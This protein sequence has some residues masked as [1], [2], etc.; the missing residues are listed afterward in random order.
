MD[1]N[2]LVSILINNYNYGNFIAEAIDSALNQNYP[3]IEVIVVDDGSTD[4]SREIIASYG[5]RIKPI[6]KKNGGQASAF[7]AGF[8]A[9]TGDFICFL[10]SDDL[11]KVD[12]V[13]A[14]VNAF[15]QDKTIG[16]YFHTLELFGSQ[17]DQKELDSVSSELSG[18]Y[19]LR[20]YIL[21][22]KLR[23]SL[24]F[25]VNIATS[26]TCCRRSLLERILP[27]SEETRITSDDYIKYAALGISKGFISFQP[28]ARQR[29]HGN[30]AYTLTPGIEKLRAKTQI[31]TACQLKEKFPEL[32]KFSNNLVAMGISIYWK[33]GSI[34]AATQKLLNTYMSTINYLEKA[35]IYTK[36]VYYR[37]IRHRLNTFG[38]KK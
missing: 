34:E 38:F 3:E 11:F 6:L 32:S 22:G 2:S 27:M 36:V 30:N 10:D 8:A 13:T 5:D 28:L 12:K 25:E 29:I 26:G 4:N 7:N 19:D 9:S 37:F 31:L 33:I 15:Q 16:W 35:K 21:R 20:P 17:L 1:K 24:P 18:I 14:V 23:G